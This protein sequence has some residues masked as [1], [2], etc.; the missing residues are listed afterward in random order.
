MFDFKIGGAVR[1]NIIVFSQLTGTNVRGP[2]SSFKVGGKQMSLTSDD[3]STGTTGFGG[4]VM[5]YVAEQG[6][7]VSAS[8]L[9]LSL[10]LRDETLDDTAE[11]LGSEKDEVF[12]NQD[13][14][15]QFRV[16][17]EWWVSAN[18]GLG[19]AAAYT[20]ASLTDAIDEESEWTVNNIGLTF[21]AT[22]N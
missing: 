12:T 19:I 3:I 10:R 21:S 2:E 9:V 15:F 22:Y 20:Y 16:G 17:K 1:P 6:I 7:Y 18:W 5:Y 14:G 13:F 11:G 8:A 4:G